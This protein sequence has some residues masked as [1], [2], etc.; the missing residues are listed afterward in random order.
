MLPLSPE[1]S[2]RT[3]LY[4][5]ATYAFGGKGLDKDLSGTSVF[6][7]SDLRSS[8]NGW[9]AGIGINHAF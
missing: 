1:M 4:A 9:Q 2:K 3:S 5:G 7:S 8:L 6:A